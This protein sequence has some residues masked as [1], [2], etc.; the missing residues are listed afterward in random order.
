GLDLSDFDD[1][2]DE[3]HRIVSAL[4]YDGTLYVRGCDTDLGPLPFCG[5]HRFGIWSVTKSTGNGLAMLRL[6]QK[7]GPEVFDERIA[8]HLE[9]TA[10]H[11]GW[12]QTTF[13]QALN[14]TTGVGEGSTNITPNNPNDGYLVGYDSWYTAMSRDARISEVFKAPD[15]PWGPGE[16]MRYR[17]Q[18]AFVLGAAMDAYL[19]SR[20][21]P[22]ADMW[23]FLMEEVY[24]P[25]GIQHAPTNRLLEADG[26][27]SLPQMSQGSYPTLDDLARIGQLL[28][29]GGRSTGQQILHEGKLAEALY[30]SPG[31]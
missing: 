7:Y 21:G 15:H 18:D 8:D 22:E 12:E 26:R 2:I 16:V 27:L 30:R 25:I 20:E 4:V 13:G 31:S 17:D 19:K 29:N 11:D 24:A 10:S 14:M 23:R 1:G 3:A 9:V 6:A 28:H 5:E